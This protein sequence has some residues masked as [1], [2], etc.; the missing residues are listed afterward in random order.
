MPTITITADY[1]GY[2]EAF[3]IVRYKFDT[4]SPI[5]V[6]YRSQKV[7]ANLDRGFFRFPLNALPA[8]A[9]VTQVRHYVYC[10]SAGGASHSLDVHAYGSNGQ[11]D[12]QPDNAATCFDRCASGNLYVDDSTE[13]RTTGDKWITLGGSICADIQNAKAAVN[14]FSLALHEEGDNDPY[15]ILDALEYS[16]G[17]P[18]Q[19]EITYEE[20]P[21]PPAGYQYSDGLVSIQVAG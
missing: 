10:R 8:G 14:R 15:A 3:G 11:E 7:G 16:G 9:T 5:Y 2:A 20:G 1:D 18:A 4:L 21:A 19:L 17:Y 6:G 12:P 13:L